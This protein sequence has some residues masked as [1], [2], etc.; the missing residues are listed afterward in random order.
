MHETFPN[1]QKNKYHL[2]LLTLFDIAI[3]NFTLFREE[4]NFE[5]RYFFNVDVN[6]KS[7]KRV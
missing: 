2:R 5:T 4:C 3:V 1:D 6:K 7:Q